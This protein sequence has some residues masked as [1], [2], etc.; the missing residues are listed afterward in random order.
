MKK[1]HLDGLL[2]SIGEARRHARGEAVAGLKVHARTV[3]PSAI[4]AIRLKAGLTQAEFAR[5][6]GASLGTIRKWEMGERSP[7]GA[8]ATL[9]RVLDFDPATVTRALGVTPEQPK[10]APRSGLVAAE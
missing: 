9:L 4:A 5:L 8:A 1:E 10:R 7:S 6:L 2:D 3:E